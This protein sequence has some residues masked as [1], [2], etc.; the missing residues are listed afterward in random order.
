MLVCGIIGAFIK[1]H[2]YKDNYDDIKKE[3]FLTIAILL[4]W[5]RAVSY[6][7]IWKR[8]RHLIHT[9]NETIYDM[10]PFLLVLI[11]VIFCY[12]SAYIAAFP[13][14]LG[15]DLTYSDRLFEGYNI[16]IGNVDFETTN[17]VT[18]LVY[19]IMTLI[20]VIVLL[21]MLIALMGE[22]F[23]RV[24][25][26]YVV[27]DYRERLSVIIDLESVMYICKRNK[28]K[29]LHIGVIRRPGGFVDGGD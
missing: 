29:L 3:W 7:R 12:C 28:K 1:N 21:N 8:T 19:V 22:T 2:T 16:L 18:Y 5:Y 24:Q 6:F 26:N 25:E 4:Q 15:K 9:I 13:E 10:I 14:E 20:P 23:G 11:M 17:A 27:Y